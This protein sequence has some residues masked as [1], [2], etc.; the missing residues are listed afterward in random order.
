LWHKNP[1]RCR[2][3]ICCDFL[4]TYNRGHTHTHGR[5]HI[6]TRAHAHTHTHRRTPLT[7]NQTLTHT[8]QIFIPSV[9]FKHAIPETKRPQT[10]DLDCSEFLLHPNIRKCA[11][12]VNKPRVLR[13]CVT[14]MDIKS[15]HFIHTMY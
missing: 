1:N 9:G 3:P 11:R 7:S 12:E 15:L 2:P 10:H 13:K 8:S 6:C 4:V 14:Y 5:T